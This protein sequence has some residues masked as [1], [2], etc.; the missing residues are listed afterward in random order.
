M[1]LGDAVIPTNY[2]CIAVLN[3]LT[4]LV[5]VLGASGSGRGGE[6]THSVEGFSQIT[7]ASGGERGMPI[8]NAS[9]L[10]SLHITYLDLAHYRSSAH[11]VGM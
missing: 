7:S 3:K 8:H 5:G 11:S 10:Y 1:N 6:T 4:F 9:L 2:I